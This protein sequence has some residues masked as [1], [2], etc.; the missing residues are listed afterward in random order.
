MWSF[1]V[2]MPP[3]HSSGEPPPP[4]GSTCD[5]HLLLVHIHNRK[6]ERLRSQKPWLHRSIA[7][8]QQQMVASLKPQCCPDHRHPT[9][10]VPESCICPVSACILSYLGMQLTARPTHGVWWAPIGDAVQQHVALLP[11]CHT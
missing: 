2:L 7:A 4:A 10:T 8:A 9:T 11:L 6:P 1:G 3:T 5:P